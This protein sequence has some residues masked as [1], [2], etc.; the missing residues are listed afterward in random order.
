MLTRVAFPALALLAIAALAGEPPPRTAPIYSTSAIA[1]LADGERG[2]LCPN[3]LAVIM[4]TGL[5]NGVWA[6]QQSD[7]QGDLLPTALPGTGVT[8]KVNGLMAAIE[9]ASP[10][11]VVFLVPSE[12]Q[13][14][15][16]TIV[17]TRSS[18]NGPVIR[19]ELSE[20][21]PALFLRADGLALG[22]HADSQELLAESR[23]AEPGEEIIIFAA[24][25][26]ATDPPILHRKVLPESAA[27]AQPERLQLF[28][29]ERPIPSDRIT[30][31]GALADQPGLY[32]IRFRLPR[33][34][35]PLPEVRLCIQDQC[36]RPGVRINAGDAPLQPASHSVRSIQ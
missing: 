1:K 14:G 31:V 18:V 32:A 34:L 4:G 12:L 8:V 24:G 15:V 20:A 30:Y 9:Y 6:R 7:L 23:Q 27:L 22:S 11:A 2:K 36:S 16:A 13:P 29:N 19:L 25:L 21:C 28:L 26:G 33:E 35:P 10:T 5:A 17:L 3:T